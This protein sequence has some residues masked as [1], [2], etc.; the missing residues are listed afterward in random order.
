MGD[1]AGLL[2]TAVLDR[3]VVDRTGLK[4]RYDFTL[5]WTPDDSQFSGMGAKIPPPT[6]GT[7]APPNLW[8]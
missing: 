2:Q 3:P 8:L 6:D 7:D 5:N 4:C 1:F